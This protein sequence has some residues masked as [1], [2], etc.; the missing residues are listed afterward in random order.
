M[1]MN[2]VLARDLTQALY[3]HR[4]PPHVSL[5]QADSLMVAHIE[6]YWAP[7]IP[8]DDLLKTLPGRDIR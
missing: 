8:S 6:R 4:M 7:S 1:G 5:T 3:N 2:V